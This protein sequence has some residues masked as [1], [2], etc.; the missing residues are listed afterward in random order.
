MAEVYSGRHT[1]LNRAC[2]VKILYAHLSEDSR[3]ITRFHTEA[4]AVAALRHPNIVQVFD[5]DVFDGRPYIVMELLEGISLETH[6]LNLCDQDQLMYRREVVR[7]TEKLAEALD[8]AHSEGVLHRDIK[9][10]NVMVCNGSSAILPG[11]PLPPDFEPVLTDFGLARISFGSEHTAPGTVLGTPAYMSPEQVEGGA[12][13]ERS[14]IY[15]LGAMT[16]ETLAGKLPFGSSD[17]T[18]ASIMYQQVH[19]PTPPLPNA[20]PALSRVMERALAKD[21]DDRQG[22]AGE[23]VK[24]L[25]SA[26]RA[27]AD[28]V[29]TKPKSRFPLRILYAGLGLLLLGGLAFISIGNVRDTGVLPELASTPTPVSTTAPTKRPPAVREGLAPGAPTLPAFPEE[30]IRSGLNLSNPDYFDPFDDPADW[31]LYD[32]EENAAYRIEGGNLIGTDYE[33]EEKFTLW[34]WLGRQSGNVYAQV[35]V[36]NG[37]CIGRDSV[38]MAV[39]VDEESARGGYGVEISCDGFW[40]LRLHHESK[41]PRD[42]VEWSRSEV[43]NSGLG[44][45]NQIGLMAFQGNF[46]VFVNNQPV[47]TVTHPDYNRSFGNF[48][49]FVRASQTYDLTAT[50][51]NFAFWH[52]RNIPDAFLP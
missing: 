12:V 47:G 19:T 11:H 50:F 4:Q 16:Y 21:P 30:D 36:I 22:T 9:P 26:I 28:T 8:Y 10:S 13:D 31:Y 37:D 33:P 40:R 23:M 5:F 14:D 44:A 46:V 52:V 27:D 35:S 25:K 15:A 42:L 48:A 43:I 18:P 1:T 51:D 29:P 39:R 34:S 7:L 49:L 2:V 17:A 41:S 32:I 20:G 24:D 3:L 45:T 38:G 6:L